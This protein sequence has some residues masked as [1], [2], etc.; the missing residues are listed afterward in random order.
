MAEQQK[1]LTVNQA[2]L[3]VLRGCE[4]YHMHHS[5][6]RLPIA[7]CQF[8]QKTAKD[9]RPKSK[10]PIGNWQSTIAN[11]WKG[12]LTGK[13]VVLKTTAHCRLQVRVLSLPPIHCRFP[14]ANCR[15]GGLRYCIF[16]SLVFGL[17]PSVFGFV[18]RI[19]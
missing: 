6:C 12:S 4:S 8:V 5:N 16:R 3:I 18:I 19:S 17:W 14:I 11:V 1:H 9:L 2:D 13:A 15:L 7:D 10:D